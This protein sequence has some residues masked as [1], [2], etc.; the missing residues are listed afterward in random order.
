M[1]ADAYPKLSSFTCAGRPM[2]G[3]FGCPINRS[4]P[5]TLEFQ[6][7]GGIDS[8]STDGLWYIQSTGETPPGQIL[9]AGRI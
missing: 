9:P 8:T 5:K 4:P 6:D 3:T 2:L 1:D 7:A